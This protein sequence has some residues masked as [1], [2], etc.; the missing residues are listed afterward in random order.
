V[1]RHLAL[2]E[3]ADFRIEGRTSSPAS[4]PPP[5]P[6]PAGQSA[7]GPDFLDGVLAKELVLADARELVLDEFERRYV[8]HALR[9]HGGNVTRAAASA[10]VA[11]RYFHVLRTK[12]AHKEE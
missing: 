4:E 3:F 5:P 7:P 10:G 11:R 6:V 9:A 12:R 2:G 8:E 1:A